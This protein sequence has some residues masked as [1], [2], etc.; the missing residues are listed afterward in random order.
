MLPGIL[1]IDNKKSGGNKRGISSLL[2]CS[3]E[4]G[5]VLKAHP[6]KGSCV[7]NK[8]SDSVG[9]QNSYSKNLARCSLAGL[10]LPCRSFVSRLLSLSL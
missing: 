7:F 8:K 9:G 6:Q 3:E 10:R 5:I 1:A 4:A 2:G